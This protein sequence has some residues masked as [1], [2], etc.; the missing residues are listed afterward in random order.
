MVAT[1]VVC[2]TLSGVYKYLPCCFILATCC[3]GS[4]SVVNMQVSRSMKF[5]LQVVVAEEVWRGL[6]DVWTCWWLLRLSQ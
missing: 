4:S 2:S 3:L 1:V 6:G 5:V